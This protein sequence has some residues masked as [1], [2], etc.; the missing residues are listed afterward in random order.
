MT[1][2]SLRWRASLL[3]SVVLVAAI[4]TISTVAYI[5]FEKSHFHEIDLKLETVADDI[6]AGLKD[7][8]GE[9]KLAETVRT[10]VGA[11]G[12]DASTFYRVW[13][14][15]SPTDLL[16]NDP[17]DS[18]HRYW[19]RELS[20][21]NGPTSGQSLSMNIGRRGNEHRAIWLRQEVDDGI[22]NVVVASSSRSIWRE[23]REFQILLPILGVSLVVTSAVAVVLSIRWGLRPIGVTA[24]RL[25]QITHPNVGNT[26]F[27]GLK[28]PEELRPFAAALTDM[29]SRL[30]KVLQQQKQFTS[31][32]AHEL[33]TP[34]A[35]V[36][37]TLQAAQMHQR[38]ADEYKHA[39]DDTLKDVARMERLIEQLLV[40]A[41]LDETDKQIA[42]TELQLDL[43]LRELAGIYD[44]KMSRSGGRAILEEP[45]ATTVRGDSDELIRL[46]GNILDNAVRY[47]PSDG[48]VRITLKCEP[49]NC[50]TVCVHDEGG[51]I[52]PEALPHLF[53]RFHRVD[54]SRSSSTGGVGLGLAIAQ[55]IARR[56]NGDISIT[57]ERSS[58]TLVSIRLPRA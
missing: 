18:E 5:E 54:H 41:R 49:D 37:S 45:P 27:D 25:H 24:E 53:E 15:G 8:K 2:L 28:V 52:P 10:A 17:P 46:F 29:L 3:V 42:M 16:V 19:L 22:V 20:D 30:D 21:Q 48:T 33:R 39:I 1:P 9:D 26:L 40:M 58:G 14:D 35:V 47:G 6:L 34:L 13:V 55:E 57:S 43:L 23:L 38:K 31:D 56:H 51:N 36:K 50:V 32:A 7:R 4:T 11:F 12:Q 44:E